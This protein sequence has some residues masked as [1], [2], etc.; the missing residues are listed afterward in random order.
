VL[1]LYIL[2][3]PLCHFTQLSVAYGALND[4]FGMSVAFSNDASTIVVGAERKK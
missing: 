4:F 1:Y 3:H 2:E